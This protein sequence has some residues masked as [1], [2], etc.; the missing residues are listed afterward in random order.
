MLRLTAVDGYTAQ[1]HYSIASAPDDTGHIELTLDHVPGGE[2][3]G[4]LHT[5]ARP[6]DTVEVRGPLSGFFAWNGDR[7][8]LLLGAGSGVVPLMSM[9]RHRR[10]RRLTVPLRLIL[11]AR[12]AEE[13]IYADEYG[14]ETTVIRTRTEGRL[15]AAHLKPY[16][17]SQPPGGWEAYVCGNNG[18]AEHASRLLADGDQPVDRIRI[19]RFG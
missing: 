15:T 19:E 12:T 18:F 16:L 11:S 1:R 14:A 3:S 17:Q 6:G 8:A 2:V 4:H 13:V 7:P 10:L 9:L 5:I